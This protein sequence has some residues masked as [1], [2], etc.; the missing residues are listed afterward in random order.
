MNATQDTFAVGD[1]VRFREVVE[2]GDAEARMI[3][4]EL[5]GERVLV[6]DTRHAHWNIK[7]TAVYPAADLVK[8]QD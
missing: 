3:V 7:P 8:A 4:L 5:R 1:T 6:T 2:A